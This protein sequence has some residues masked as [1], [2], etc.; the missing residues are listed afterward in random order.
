MNQ[1]NIETNSQHSVRQFIEDSHTSGALLLT[2]EWGSGKTYFLKQLADEFN[3]I[4]Y[5]I[6]HISLF[7]RSSAEEIEKDIKKKLCY[8]FASTDITN[9]AKNFDNNEITTGKNHKFKKIRKKIS[10]KSTV[11]KL[12][13]G[14]RVITN[15]FKEDSKLISGIDSLINFNYLDFID[16]EAEIIGRK[17]VIIFDD[18]ERCPIESDLL[19][20]IINEYS[21]NIGIKVII[22]AND[23]KIDDSS[24]F[25]QYKEKVVYRTIKLEQNVECVLEALIDEFDSR[26][27]EYQYFLKKHCQLIIN[28]FNASK[29]NNFRSL[30]TAI[31]DFE[32]LYNLLIEKTQFLVSH[33]IEPYEQKTLDFLLEQFLAFI[34]EYA[35][36][37]NIYEYF[38]ETFNDP[39]DEDENGAPICLAYTPDNIPSFVSKYRQEIFDISSVPKAII[40]WIVKGVYN[41][42][43]IAKCIDAYFEKNKPYQIED[44]ELL[45]STQILFLDSIDIFNNGYCTALQ[46]AY[47]GDLTSEQYISLLHQIRQ[48]KMM[49]INLPK[50]PLYDKMTYGFR[51]KDRSNE[52]EPV[53]SGFSGWTEEAAIDLKKEIEA[54]I[55]NRPINKKIRDYYNYCL[56]YFNRCNID[57]SLQLLNSS[58]EIKL[59]DE[60]IDA[61]ISAFKG[62]T[63]RK[64]REIACYFSNIR[65]SN[66]ENRTLSD[67]LIK[68]LSDL[69][70]TDIH[71]PIGIA[72]LTEFIS[73]VKK[74]FLSD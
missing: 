18:F 58:T 56:N 13:K 6:V 46:K 41:K 11:S 26:G 33:K 1:K 30:R 51:S 44:W 21:E 67:K 53:L 29:S 64:R 59:N 22:V 34:M 47:D 20:G 69:N 15:H 27:S 57:D 25:V 42:D 5:A 45:L 54:S 55:H 70:G 71:D 19:L 36:G 23:D 52:E 2:G 50:E 16:L 40:E 48:A 9:I 38:Y 63:N 32:K 74:Q 8:I 28:V 12:V 37:E 14:L 62:A 3:K 72:N 4:D 35:A 31:N 43:A 65:F 24:K 10:E 60:L 17:V 68:K 66:H 7:G 49:K 61:V 73:K 39:I